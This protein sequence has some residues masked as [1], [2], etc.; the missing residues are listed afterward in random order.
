MDKI[1][2][3]ILKELDFLVDEAL[4]LQQAVFETKTPSNSDY[5]LFTKQLLIM[6]TRLG[7]YLC[8]KAHPVLE[9]V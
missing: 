7:E 8:N 4:D 3:G 5:L 9:W 1:R 6:H 2:L